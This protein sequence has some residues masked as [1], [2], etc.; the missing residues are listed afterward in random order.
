MKRL[1]L[2]AGLVYLL[3]SCAGS[4]GFTDAK[5]TWTGSYSVEMPL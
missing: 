3:M 1:V 2:F 4:P 5:A